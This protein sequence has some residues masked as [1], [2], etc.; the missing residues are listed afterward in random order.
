MN[1]RDKINKTLENKKISKVI[2]SKVQKSISDISII[3]TTTA[4]YIAK[5][6]L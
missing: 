5:D 3:I 1:V 2:I 4:N 6:L